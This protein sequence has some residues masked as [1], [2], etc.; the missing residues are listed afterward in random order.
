MTRM[1]SEGWL[2]WNAHIHNLGSTSSSANMAIWTLAESGRNIRQYVKYLPLQLVAPKSVSGPLFWSAHVPN[3]ESKG[4]MTADSASRRSGSKNKFTGLSFSQTNRPQIEVYHGIHTSHTLPWY[5][6]HL[7]PTRSQGGQCCSSNRQG[8]RLTMRCLE[9]RH[10]SHELSSQ[11]IIVELTKYSNLHMD[12]KVIGC[13]FDRILRFYLFGGCCSWVTD[14]L[15][16]LLA[17]WCD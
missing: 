17:T 6:P 16:N 8:C 13:Y 7:A 4:Q 3:I 11:V 9:F 15:K 1:T 12:R 10:V 5:L 14:E 2:V